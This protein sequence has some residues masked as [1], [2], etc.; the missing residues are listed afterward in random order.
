M[1]ALAKLIDDAPAHGAGADD[2]CGANRQWFRQADLGIRGGHSPVT[3]ECEFESAA[4]RDPVNR[5]DQGLG[6]R[7]H[8]RLYFARDGRGEHH[9]GGDLLEIGAGGE[10]PLAGQN[11]GPDLWVARGAL[12]RCHQAL[13][14]RQTERVD[15]RVRDGEDGDLAVLP[16]VHGGH[17]FLRLRECPAP[18]RPPPLPKARPVGADSAKLKLSWRARPRPGWQASH[19]S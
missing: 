16:I 7:F 12:K 8:L 13:A 6:Q 9:P 1:P 11:E 3:G 4:E 10:G 2:R 14:H 19:P 17:G 18:Q 5:R 15:R